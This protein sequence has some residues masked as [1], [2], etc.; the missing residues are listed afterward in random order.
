MI[1]PVVLT[2]YIGLGVSGLLLIMLIFIAVK[3]P[4]FKF[5]SCMIRNKVLVLEKMKGIPI[6]MFRTGKPKRGSIDLKD[7]RAITVKDSGFLDNKSKVRI[8]YSPS[9]MS[10]TAPFDFYGILDCLEKRL[11]IKIKNNKEYKEAIRE[12]KTN[13]KYRDEKTGR[14]KP[15]EMQPYRTFEVTDLDEYFPQNITAEAFHSTIEREKLEERRKKALT[16]DI[17]K[18]AIGGAIFLIALSVGAKILLDQIAKNPS[19][20]Q[21]VWEG[22][23]NAAQ[24]IVTNATKN[25]TTV[26]PR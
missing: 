4:A 15:L 19:H 16:G 22:V 8:F 12:Y 25:V 26:I 3:T 5:L 23:Q 10:S 14:P 7:K 1:H 20:V 24:T 21:C 9:N 13:Q 18:W 6:V 2:M 11:G 17:M